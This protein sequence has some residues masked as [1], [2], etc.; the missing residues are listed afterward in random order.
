MERIISTVIAAL[1]DEGLN[2]IRGYDGSELPILEE[3]L[4]AVSMADAV[5]FPLCADSV[6]TESASFRTTG[7]MAESVLLI[8]LYDDYRHGD[9]PC[10][11][12]A[13]LAASI[14]SRL[15]DSFTCGKIQLGCVHYKADYDCFCCNIK[16]PIRVY[17]ARKDQI[18]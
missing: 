18:A 7:L 4:C 9:S 11:S 14:C 10:V 5:Y 16:I 13:I 12:A 2:A 3:P 6:I 1:Q 17:M 15:H 8:D